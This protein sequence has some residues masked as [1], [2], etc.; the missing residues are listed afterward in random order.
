[1]PHKSSK[2][3][4]K[5]KPSKKAKSVKQVLSKVKKGNDK[6]RGFNQMKGYNPDRKQGL[7]AADKARRKGF[8]ISSYPQYQGFPEDNPNRRDAIREVMGTKAHALE[9]PAQNYFNYTTDA[10]HKHHRLS[11]AQRTRVTR[12]YFQ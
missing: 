4:A 10:M 3:P 5:P 8:E 12:R 9:M 11:E 1:M 2:Q 7:S 6:W